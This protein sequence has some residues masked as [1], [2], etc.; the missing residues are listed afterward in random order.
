MDENTI[1]K[2]NKINNDFYST[3]ATDFDDSRQ[4]FWEGWKKLIHYTKDFNQLKSA[5]IGC[6]NGRFFEFL[7]K[8]IPKAEISYLG[9]DNNEDLLKFAK[10]NFKKNNFDNYQLKKIDIIE[11]LLSKN[12]FLKED[13]KLQTND[14]FNLIV[15]FGVMHHIPS[16]K[17][18]L[19]LI[20]YLK[21]K[22]SDNGYIILSLWQFM[23]F[24]RFRKKVVN[25]NNFEENDYILDWNR[26][27]K[28]LRYCHFIDEVEQN[29]LIFDSKLKLVERFR[30]DG[31]EGNV[32][33]YLVLKK[34]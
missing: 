33:T 31:K 22:I 6:G 20:S 29:N 34:Q 12:D 17:L 8:N 18:R 9:I 10:N 16:Y 3:V 21:S 13:Q 19:Q 30:A 7:I 5:D 25:Y 23:E 24:E 15:S 11:S 27:K 14:G 26:G 1:L 2:L 32:N 4:Y 28:A